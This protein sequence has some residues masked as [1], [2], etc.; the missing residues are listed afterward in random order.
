[1]TWWCWHV[2]APALQSHWLFVCVCPSGVTVW[3]VGG[4][5]G[6]GE[7][8]AAVRVC[9][10]GCVV[11]TCMYVCVCVHVC[12]REGEGVLC[13]SL[14]EA[15][16]HY[17]GLSGQ[18]PRTSH[19]WVS[20]L[21]SLPCGRWLPA[22]TWVAIPSRLMS[23]TASLSRPTT[24]RSIRCLVCV[25]V[26][27]CVWCVRACVWVWVWECVCTCG[28]ASVLQIFSYLSWYFTTPRIICWPVLIT[29]LVYT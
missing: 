21:H 29:L 15:T 18:T 1:M 8:S 24:A 20:P 3:E 2:S 25:C 26:C 27:M 17:I 23:R 7:S 9:V 12:V 4:W 28:L 22:L 19:T 6:H 5:G 16:I 10:W 14:H 11:C 13:V